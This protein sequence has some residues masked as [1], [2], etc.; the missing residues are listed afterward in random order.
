MKIH[1]RRR[2]IEMGKR[3]SSRECPVA[4]ACAEVFG[5]VVSV[6]QWGLRSTDGFHT[7]P[8]PAQRFIDN[9][10]SRKPVKPFTFVLK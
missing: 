7:L 5:G 2:H 9:F 4:L 1:V 10:D 3:F 6:S 8:L